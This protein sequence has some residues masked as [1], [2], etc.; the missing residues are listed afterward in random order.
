[1]AVLPTPA[2]PTSKGLFFLRRDS[3]C[4]KRSNS[5]PRP[6]SGSMLPLRASA[7]KS[8]VYLTKWLA[9]SPSPSTV[10]SEPSISVLLTP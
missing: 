10:F 4:T 8:V 3:T 7:F 9:S 2:S 1:M 6:M 5:L